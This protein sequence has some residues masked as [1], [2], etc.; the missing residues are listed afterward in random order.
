MSRESKCLGEITIILSDKIY[1]IFISIHIEASWN[2]QIVLLCFHVYQVKGKSKNDIFSQR[3]A[4]ISVLTIESDSG[5]SAK[6]M[7]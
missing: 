3:S 4:H 1:I 7:A 6:A 2:F 5:H